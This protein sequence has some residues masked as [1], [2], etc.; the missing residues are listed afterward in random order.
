[1]IHPSGDTRPYLAL[2]MRSPVQFRVRAF[3]RARKVVW[4][5][6]FWHHWESIRR[7]FLTSLP[8]LEYSVFKSQA[9]ARMLIAYT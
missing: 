5:T 3:Y 8:T 4:G 9:A 1:M 2:W 7:P 6:D